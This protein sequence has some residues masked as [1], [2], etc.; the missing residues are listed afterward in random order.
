MHEPAGVVE[1][2]VQILQ[3]TPILKYSFRIPPPPRKW[4]LSEILA[5]Q[6][7]S[8]S[9]LCVASYHM[10]RLYPA[11]ITNRFVVHSLLACFESWSHLVLLNGK[12][13]SANNS[14]SAFHFLKFAF[15]HFFSCHSCLHCVDTKDVVVF[16][17]IQEATAVSFLQI[18]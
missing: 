9:E 18:L 15:I 3:N 17:T 13:H 7:F 4:K 8:V 14:T 6:D 1:I 2:L 16:F 10:W 11:R 5:L 12:Q